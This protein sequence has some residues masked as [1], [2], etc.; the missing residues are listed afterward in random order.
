MEYVA[1]FSHYL[2]MLKG[3]QKDMGSSAFTRENLLSNAKFLKII[4]PLCL[5]C[6]GLVVSLVRFVNTAAIRT[7]AENKGQCVSQLPLQCSLV[8]EAISSRTLS[9]TST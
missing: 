7:T 9:E 1:V 3:Y 2:V 4:R 8:A 5:W 6:F